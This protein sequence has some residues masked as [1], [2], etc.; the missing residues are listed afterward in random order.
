MK[1]D[2]LHLHNFTSWRRIK[3][4]FLHH[5]HKP[6]LDLLVWVLVTKLAPSYYRK[7]GQLTNNKGRY[8]EL[9]SWR[10]AFKCEWKKCAKTPITLPLND[11]YRPDVRRWVCT[12]PYFA[13]SRFLLCKHLI[14]SVHPVLPAFFLEVRHARTAPF[15]QHAKLVPLESETNAEM[16]IA[17]NPVADP[18]G[19]FSDED[20]FEDLGGEGDE[21][22]GE[23]VD[24]ESGIIEGGKTFGERMKAHVDL[25]R[26]FSDGLEYQI[27]F[28]DTRML[29]YLEREGRSLFRL[30]EN[31]L[32]RER[33]MN[34]TRGGS[35][36]TWESAT[37]NAMYYRTRP[38]PADRDMDCAIA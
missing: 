3:R 29:D 11:K 30:A 34:S 37:A 33:R 6:R 28:G 10:K 17:P 36:T 20:D 31:C 25:L 23:V 32:S 15:W 4:D 7:L 22:E 5:F 8:R 21:S 35:P 26:N 14:Q 13:T 18:I 1:V 16:P 24:T 12:C 38:A 19:D 9:P 27:Q 2:D